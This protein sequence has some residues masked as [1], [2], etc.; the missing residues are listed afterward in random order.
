[1]QFILENINLL[2]AGL[3][4]GFTGSFFGWFFTRKQ[5]N[6]QA[7]STEIDNGQKIIDLYQKTL[8]DLKQRYEEKYNELRQTYDLKILSLQQQIELLTKEH[9]DCT[10][11]YNELKRKLAAKK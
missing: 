6:A 1:M 11:Q 7:E 3:I 4:S 10:R 9:D 5:Y 8:D 2:L